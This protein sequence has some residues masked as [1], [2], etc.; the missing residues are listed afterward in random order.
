MSVECIC[1][2]ECD[3]QNPEPEHGVALV[4]NMCPIHNIRPMA[5]QECEAEEHLNGAY[6]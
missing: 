1:P 2:P 3:C 4:S 5:D 6:R